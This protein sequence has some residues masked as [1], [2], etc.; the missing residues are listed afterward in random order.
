MT[1]PMRTTTEIARRFTR[2]EESDTTL[3][4]TRRLENWG[5]IGL[6][7]PE[8]ERSTGRGR[9]RSY[10]EFEQIKAAVLLLAFAYQSPKGLLELISQLF[11]D[12][13]SA[14]KAERSRGTRPAGTPKQKTVE[15]MGKLLDAARN[16]K[17]VVYLILKSTELEVLPQAYFGTNLDVLKTED[18]GLVV[19]VNR[20]IRRVI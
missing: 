2:S 16:G 1:A 11:D 5:N 13:R 18:S 8:G 6:L 20:A 9:A 19:N 10:D 14:R 7:A 12:V 3:R 4:V 15:R 17:K